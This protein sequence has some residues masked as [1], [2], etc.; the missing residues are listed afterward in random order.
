MKHIKTFF[1][2][3]IMLFAFNFNVSAQSAKW[4]DIGKYQDNKVLVQK[5]KQSDGKTF[6]VMFEIGLK[7]Y[8]DAHA[9]TLGQTIGE[10]IE[11]VDYLIL[12]IDK[13]K[14]VSI[15]DMLAGKTYLLYSSKAEGI[16]INN[17]DAIGF[18]TP[19]TKPTLYR[20]RIKLE[21][22]Q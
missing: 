21:S 11:T 22:M 12:L 8:H 19:V 14:D 3:F 7:S 18:G 1:I 13:Q 6:Y 10:S 9:I 17:Y 5:V 4:T 16:S 20:I 2:A 15:D